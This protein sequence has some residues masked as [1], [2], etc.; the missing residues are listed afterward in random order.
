[1]TAAEM[2][3][4][5][6]LLSGDDIGDAS[7]NEMIQ[8][9]DDF[10]RLHVTN[11][12]SELDEDIGRVVENRE[13]KRQKVNDL[14]YNDSDNEDEQRSPLKPS[15]D[16][17]SKKSGQKINIFDMVKNSGDNDKE[18]NNVYDEN[19]MEINSEDIRSRIAQL[20]DSDTSD[21]EQTAKAV[22]QPR[23]RIAIVDSD[24][25]DDDV[26]MIGNSV[27]N[28]AEIVLPN[29]D[30]EPNSEDFS[31]QAIQSRLAAL[32]DSDS[33]T[34]LAIGKQTIENKRHSNK[35]ERSASGDETSNDGQALISQNKKKAKKL[36]IEDEDD[37]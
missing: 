6:N 24:S 13:A 14:M 22:K 27:E 12:D 26:Q 11:S 19:E 33:D 4:R 18:A 15:K 32:E 23:K 5:S 36:L 7:A 29:A 3:L 28:D 2:R 31:S 10:E 20:D 25:E 17:K 8:V 34:E 1:M 9:D 16:K 21:V 37:E 35:R 30:M